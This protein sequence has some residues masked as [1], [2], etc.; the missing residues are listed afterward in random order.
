MKITMM[1]ML[2]SIDS[3]LM[4]SKKRIDMRIR[5]SSKLCFHKRTDS[6]KGNKRLIVS[7]VVVT[8]AV[9][10]AFISKER[11]LVIVVAL[12]EMHSAIYARR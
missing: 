1:V 9:L 10:L 4:N 12:E 11:V 6:S 8:T 2:L 5:M 3:R 7:E